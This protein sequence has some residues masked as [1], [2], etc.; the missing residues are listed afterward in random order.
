[1]N[2][3]I[4]LTDFVKLSFNIGGRILPHVVGHNL[5]K[6]VVSFCPYLPST[7]FGSDMRWIRKLIVP[8]M[9]KKITKRCSLKC[10]IK[11]L[12]RN[13]QQQRNK[14]NIIQLSNLDFIT[15]LHNFF[16]HTFKTVN[17]HN[18]KSSIE[19]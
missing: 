11:N 3:N 8:S 4:A 5:S 2:L 17:G 13:K 1:M 12:I 19:R 10:F 16:N 6:L 18:T 15:I 9:Y 7:T 14:A